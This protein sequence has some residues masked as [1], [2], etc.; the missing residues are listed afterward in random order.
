[1]QVFRHH[2]EALEHLLHLA[3]YA[4]GM[5]PPALL[6][7]HYS[8]AAAGIGSAKWK[9]AFRAADELPSDLQALALGEAARPLLG[10]EGCEAWRADSQVGPEDS[11]VGSVMSQDLSPVAKANIK[12]ERSWHR[13][14]VACQAGAKAQVG[15]SAEV[16]LMAAAHKR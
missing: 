12:T 16:V 10:S 4:M 8:S 2:H 5:K 1:M 3:Y 14:A 15:A 7:R 11:A 13:I 9:Q 6:K